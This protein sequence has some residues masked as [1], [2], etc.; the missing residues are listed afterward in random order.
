METRDSGTSEWASP[1]MEVFK[2]DKQSLKI[3]GDFKQTI[4]LLSKLDHYQ[5]TKVEDLFTH[6]LEE[7]LI[8]SLI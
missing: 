6:T 1:I 3:C 8:P 7:S 5:I 4:N 2:S